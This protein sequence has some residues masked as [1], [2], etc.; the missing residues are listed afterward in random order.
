V[1]YDMR[2]PMVR[3]AVAWLQRVQQPGGGWGETCRTYDE[4]ALAGQGT[5][6][7]SQTAWA[8]L[9]LLAAGEAHRD[10]VRAGIEYLLA[11]Q[12]ADGSWHEEHFTGTGFPKV[13]YLKYHMY[14]LYFP[15]MALA[16]YASALR[17]ASGGCEPPDRLSL[18]G[19]ASKLPAGT[20]NGKGDWHAFSPHPHHRDG[21]LHR[22]QETVRGEA[23]S[24]GA[25]A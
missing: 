2:R 14:A 1:G 15:L 22:T 17:G 6:T 19:Q 9:G 21:R 11:T 25:D 10:T 24:S 23:L 4:P 13:F 8:L 7:A 5:P 20:E 18:N 3:R 12:Q 16:R